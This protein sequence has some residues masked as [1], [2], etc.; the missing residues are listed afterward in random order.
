MSKK[1]RFTLD[2][3]ECEQSPLACTHCTQKHR[4]TSAYITKTI[5]HTYP[6]KTKIDHTLYLYGAR[7]CVYCTEISKGKIVPLDETDC[8]LFRIFSRCMNRRE[9]V[10]F[11][12]LD[13]L[14]PSFF[15]SSLRQCFLPSVFWSSTKIHCLKMHATEKGLA[16]SMWAWM[17]VCN[18]N[19]AYANF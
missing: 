16:P 10:Y 15:L 18:K 17:C 8:S 7:F 14:S 19:I 6:G 2:D 11:S 1:L 13:S 9:R 5:S 3:A 12:S 4:H